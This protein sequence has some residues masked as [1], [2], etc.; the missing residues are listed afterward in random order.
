MGY[1]SGHKFYKSSDIGNSFDLLYA[2]Y[3]S[4]NDVNKP[5]SVLN[6]EHIFLA[7]R[8]NNP[9]GILRSTDG[10]VTWEQVLFRRV[11]TV[12]TNTDGLILT[13]STVASIYDTNKIYL[14]NNYGN[15]WDSLAQPTKWGIYITD[16]VK[17]KANKYFFGTSGD[18]LYEIEIITGVE[19]QW[20]Q[21]FHFNLFQNFPNPF[22][23]KTK[24]QYMVSGRQF[25]SLKIYD[26]LGREVAILIDEEIQS[27]N[28][29]I[30]FDASNLTSGIYFYQMKTGE[31]MQTKKMILLK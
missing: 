23:H 25:I 27:G 31:L 29:E 19:E 30:E 11:A 14:S 4:S 9:N 16:M 22:N 26:L 8:G 21:I 13:G 20:A 5:I 3:S 6:N 18:G 1:V 10:G 28:Y 7:M 12:L 15:S 17:D 2:G 24:I